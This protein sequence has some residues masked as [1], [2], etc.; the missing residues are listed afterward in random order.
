MMRRQPRSWRP[1]QA[2]PAEVLDDGAVH[3]RRNR[4]VEQHALVAVDLAQ[5]V[6]DPLIERLVVDLAGDV[7]QPAG[8]RLGDLVAARRADELLQAVAELGPELVIAHR[9]PRHAD[10]RELRRQPAALRQPVDGRQQLALGEVAGGAEDDERGR[11]RRRFEA[12]AVVQGIGAHSR[13]S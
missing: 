4:E 2:G 5:L 1:G 10:D 7:V 8:E 11:T 13:R 12:E 3:R 6:L 9:R